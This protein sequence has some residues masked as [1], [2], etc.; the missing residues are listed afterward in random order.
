MSSR[1]IFPL[2]P[3]NFVNAIARSHRQKLLRSGEV[4]HYSDVETNDGLNSFVKLPSLKPHNRTQLTYHISTTSLDLGN[5]PP[6]NV[7]WLKT[8][9]KFAAERNASILE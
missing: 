8:L 9:V 5:D 6:T 1:F 7:D 4:K 2:F 3:E